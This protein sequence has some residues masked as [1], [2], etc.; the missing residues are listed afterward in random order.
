MVN[1]SK[2]EYLE[3]IRKRYHSAGRKY[4]KRILDEFCE[5]CG[6]H[7]KHAIRLLNRKP[8]K[9]RGR[10]GRPARY[11]RKEHTVLER[12]WHVA[13]RPCSRR[14]KSMLANWLP[15]YEQQYGRLDKKTK[16]N[17]LRIS[18]NSI[19]RLLKPTRKKYG[20][21]GRC[22]TRPGTQLLH[23]IPI[24]T[25]HWDVSEPGF[26]QADTVGHGSD[27]TEGNFVQSSGIKT[28]FLLRLL[29]FCPLCCA[30]ML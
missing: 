10:R 28:A 29:E 11:G 6:H 3:K 17:L 30:A 26:M 24:K 21:R 20:A 15:S 13:T 2:R 8:V 14:L 12:I 1:E 5:V 4:K 22:G 27:S 9:C 18:K 23:Q 7:R 19:D 16:E 25:S